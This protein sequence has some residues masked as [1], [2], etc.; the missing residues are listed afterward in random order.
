MENQNVPDPRAFD[1]FMLC[2]QYKKQLEAELKATKIRS[3]ARKRL[4]F[5]AKGH[6]EKGINCLP[7]ASVSTHN[8]SSSSSEESIYF[9]NHVDFSSSPIGGTKTKEQKN[10]I[11]AADN[12]DHIQSPKHREH[13]ELDGS[14]EFFSATWPDGQIE[15]ITIPNSNVMS[16]GN[17]PYFGWAVCQFAQKN[18]GANGRGDSKRRWLYCLG[19]YSCEL[20]DFVA[21]PLL[22]PSKNKRYGSAP[23]EPKYTCPLH[24]MDKLVW[25]ECTGNG[26]NACKL[27]LTYSKAM[28]NDEEDII[29]MHGWFIAQLFYE[30]M[31]MEDKDC[32]LFGNE[33]LDY[34]TVFHYKDSTRREET[35]VDLMQEEMQV[36]GDDNMGDE[37]DDGGEEEYEWADDDKVI[38]VKEN[39]ASP[40]TTRA[41]KRKVPEQD[42]HYREQAPP[43]KSSRIP[44]GWSV[45]APGDGNRRGPRPKCKGCGGIIERTAKCIRHNRIEV[46]KKNRRYTSLDQYHCAMSCLKKVNRKVLKQLIRNKFCFADEEA[47]KVLR[48]LDEQ[49]NLSQ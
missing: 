48:E 30:V 12:R 4:C 2:W 47:A 17:I 44:Y 15:C 45:R 3:L 6:N 37:E 32:K 7:D 28:E 11:S 21:R 33:E 46:T 19:V 16:S 5:I 41:R 13:K 31:D 38:G 42:D 36:I 1:E 29:S 20:C 14:D 24:P 43:R 23:K 8:S 25:Q 49:L 39:M 26:G 10:N 40:G 9:G 27:I 34:S 35:E 22:P 18:L